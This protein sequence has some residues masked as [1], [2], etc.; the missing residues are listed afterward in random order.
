MS[1]TTIRNCDICGSDAN[2]QVRSVPCLQTTEE[3]EGRAITPTLSR[4][5]IDV[6]L[7]CFI[8]IKNAQPLSRAGAMGHNTYTLS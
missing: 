2:V 1:V 3:A 6:C 8:R 7:K 4:A 5:D